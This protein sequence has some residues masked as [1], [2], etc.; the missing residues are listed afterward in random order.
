MIIS[1]ISYFMKSVIFVYIT[2]ISLPVD[3][4]KNN[5]QTHFG[6]IWLEFACLHVC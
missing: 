4:K 3:K 5:G 1:Y 2:H 6:L